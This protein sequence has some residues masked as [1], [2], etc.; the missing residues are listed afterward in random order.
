MPED[1]ELSKAGRLTEMMEGH[2]I[3]PDFDM[4]NTTWKEAS[5]AWVSLDPWILGED[6]EVHELHAYVDGSGQ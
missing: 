6:A 5:R 3:I 4:G 1:I 2:C